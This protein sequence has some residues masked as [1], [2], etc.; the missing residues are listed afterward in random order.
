MA[1]WESLGLG[2]SGWGWGSL[3]VSE[4]SGVGLSGV[5]DSTVS[6]WGALW[7]SG[8]LWL[9]LGLSLGFSNGPPNN[10]ESC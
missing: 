10:R 5:L 4:V 8:S 7:L 6:V 2:R 3:G 1:L 9:A